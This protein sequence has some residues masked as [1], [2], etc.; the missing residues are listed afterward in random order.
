MKKG[1]WFFALIACLITIA[2]RYANSNGVWQAGE[3][4]TTTQEVSLDEFLSG[5]NNDTYTKLDLKNGRELRGYELIGTGTAM[6]G[7]QPKEIFTIYTT[8]KPTDTS[9]LELGIDLE[10]A[11][12]PVNVT[13]DETSFFMSLLIESILP[14]LLFVGI[15]F[16]LIRMMSKWGWGWFSPF[17]N[18]K[19]GVLRTPKDSDIK[20]SDVAGMAEVKEELIEI[21]DFL[22]NPKKYT[23]LWAKIP[24]W[25]LLYGEPGSGKTLLAKA[26]AGE[27]GV[28]FFSASWSEFMEMLVG[29]W[30]AKV[31]ELF[32]KAK[33]ASPSIIFIDEIDSIGRKRWWGQSGGHQEQEQTLN[34][35]L[36]EMDGFDTDTSV[37]VVAATN[38]PDT[39]DS[40]L[41]RS[42]RFDRKVMVSRPTLE[43]RKLILEYH[44]KGKKFVDD[45]DF[46]SIIR[47][48]SWQ[49]GADLANILNEAALKSAKEDRKAITN[50][51]L[52]YALEKIAM[53]PE[54]K[55]KSLKDKER[56][57]VTY[58]EL[59]HAVTAYH[60][61][62][63]D[64]VEK[65]SIV[66][67]GRALWVTWMIP[68]EDTYLT[69]KAEFLDKLVT[70]LGG[71]AAEQIF[72]WS[73]HITTGASNDFERVTKIASSMILKYGMD[74][75]LGQIV[76]ENIWWKN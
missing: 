10:N 63:A 57:I 20:F 40:A 59:W 17:G 6:L 34:Q 2:L 18:M 53:W 73:D 12:K 11:D 1:L 19:A 15:W 54:K 55:I 71:R 61:E 5:Y 60:L 51:D 62:H 29:M 44:A 8:N 52:D 68:A 43:E 24:K 7:L 27:A 33:A 74:Q 25:V 30:A 45:I 31:R 50:E 46:D 70:L 64:P 13:Y 32:K 28:P 69:S 14:I 39:L 58:H 21:V 37:I 66:S 48:T 23:D 75:D 76:Y 3:L 65:I 26:V 9:L 49:V 72:F 41:L 36:T 67:R 38:R 56:K 35:I 47:R 42:G 22:K 16:F 4:A